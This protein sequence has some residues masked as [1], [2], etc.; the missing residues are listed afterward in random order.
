MKGTIKILYY[1][2]YLILSVIESIKLSNK[3]IGT[4]LSNFNSKDVNISI[5]ALDIL[6]TYL[7]KPKYDKE[8]AL[9]IISKT[10]IWWANNNKQGIIIPLIEGGINVYTLPIYTIC[11]NVIDD[12]LK[13]ILK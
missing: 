4:N 8:L 7:D 10:N 1:N 3:G 2:G 12:K 13:E 5:D 9:E 6:K 11:S